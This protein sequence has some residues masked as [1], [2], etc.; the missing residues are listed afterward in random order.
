MTHGAGECCLESDVASENSTIPSAT[1]GSSWPVIQNRVSS[2]LP[3]I[4]RTISVGR[5]RDVNQSRFRNLDFHHWI[6][7][8]VS[9]HGHQQTFIPVGYSPRLCQWLEE[10]GFL[11]HRQSTDV[12]DSFPDK[13]AG[14]S[15]ATG[16]L[17]WTTDLHW[18]GFTL[19]SPA[20]RSSAS[21]G[22]EEVRER[23]S[24]TR[25]KEA[26]D[27]VQDSASEGLIES[28][29]FATPGEGDV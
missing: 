28:T 9:A 23:S 3:A 13:T 12:S 17:D 26:S 20:E 16:L 7:N 21:Y 29:G 1:P 6:G 11:F 2:A 5:F 22:N 25:S 8:P 24:E 15:R 18:V 14:C 10:T 19:S 27:A 4:S